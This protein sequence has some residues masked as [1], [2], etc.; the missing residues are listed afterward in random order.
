[1]M[2]S[3][4]SRESRDDVCLLF[5]IRQLS[6]RQALEILVV[7]GGAV[8]EQEP[9]HV[10]M[11]FA[12]STMQGSVAVEITDCI[13]VCLPADEQL[14]AIVMSI[15]S[16]KMKRCVPVVC[17]RVQVCSVGDKSPHHIDVPLQL[18]S[19]MQRCHPYV[20]RRRQALPSCRL[21]GVGDG[22]S[23]LV[24]PLALVRVIARRDVCVD[25][26]AERAR[27]KGCLL[28]G[29]HSVVHFCSSLHQ[30]PTDLREPCCR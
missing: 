24:A 10:R 7:L 27:D 13:D 15:G 23:D 22:L 9:D 16:C 19:S 29:G 25:V 20:I 1:M 17:L 4:R 30:Y 8:L 18:H 12:D 2:G 26:I 14:A 6:D 21:V 11:A 3:N 28:G 5:A